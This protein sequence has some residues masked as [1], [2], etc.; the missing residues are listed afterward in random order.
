MRRP[1]IALTLIA[2]WTV[3]D[4]GWAD[5]GTIP[6]LRIRLD[7]A[8]N[9]P[10]PLRAPM[11]PQPPASGQPCLPDQPSLPSAMPFG[12]APAAPQA[13][14]SPQYPAPAA[15]APASAP[16]AADLSAFSSITSAP[17]GDSFVAMTA[18]GYLDPAA[19]MNVFRFR[20]DSE[21]HITAPDRAEFFYAKSGVVGGRGVSDLES[22][23]NA[24]ELRAYLEV[25][26]TNR[27]SVFAEV[28]YRILD[29]EQN[30]NSR[31]IG[32][33]SF[34]TKTALV[35]GCD[36]ILSF[37]L[38]GYGPSGDAGMGLGNGH[39]TVEPSLLAWR[40][41]GERIQVYAQF[42]D[43][44]PITDSDFAGNIVEYGLGASYT[45]IDTGCCRVSPIAEVLGWS[46]LSGREFTGLDTPV[47]LIVD[48]SGTTIINGKIGVRIE[49][50][51][52]SVYFG[53][54]HALTSDF[55]YRDMLRFEYRLR[56]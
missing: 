39:W 25:A 20:Y 3:V 40:K 54:S 48:S 50:D 19:P 8:E 9:C 27:F 44:I 6:P 15:P 16:A 43:W 14:T 23:V 22:A 42:G 11:M 28:P 47:P 34:G 32:D 37:Q 46:I 41:V 24:Q 29:P 13:P 10:P 33:V 35:M 45:L 12:P 36:R 30:D 2:C 56:F 1:L 26:P 52:Q 31:G 7:S 53:Y 21:Y 17:L 4:F 55:W 38:K 5:S 49:S 18:P 51:R